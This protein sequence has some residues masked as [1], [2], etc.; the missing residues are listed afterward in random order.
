MGEIGTACI[1]CCDHG[2]LLRTVLNRIVLC[3]FLKGEVTC[4]FI[5]FV[6]CIINGYVHCTTGKVF[7]FFNF[8]A[9]QNVPV[10]QFILPPGQLAPGGKLPR[11]ILPPTLVIFTPRGTS[12]PGW[13]AR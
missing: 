5:D 11:D 10:S 2:T 1:Y 4:V 12:C 6:D 13:G 7:F 8:K 3:L 9:N